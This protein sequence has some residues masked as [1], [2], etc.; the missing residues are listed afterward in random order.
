MAEMPGQERTERATPKRVQDARREGRIPRSRELNT[1]LMMLAASGGM[2]VLGGG[3][4]SGMANL[5]RADF[6]ISR[7]QIFDTAQM[8]R[9]FESASLDALAII[10]P[11]MLLMLLVAV[12][13]PM[14]LGG[15][16]FSTEALGVK[17]ERLDP[18]KGFGRIFAANGLVELVKSMAKVALIGACAL[19]VLQ[20]QAPALLELSEE[21]SGA[22]MAHAMH[23]AGVAFLAM[24]ASLVIVAI[25]DVPFQ[26][27]E[28]GRGL[29]MS[30]QEV[31]DEMKDTEGKPEV[32]GRI[33]RL[34]QEVAR[35]RMMSEVPK[36][37]VIVTN[38]VHY[39]VALRYDE[40]RMR[41]PRVVAKGAELIAAR[42]REVGAEHRV[43]L[44]RAPMLA[45]ALYFNTDIGEEIPAGLY[46][47]VA[48]V[49]AYVFGLRARNDLRAELPESALPNLDI[50]EDLRR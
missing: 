25:A 23:L 45:R 36:A 21:P 37:D 8:T 9:M 41:A 32:R 24:S 13:A 40:K 4:A 15:F 11:F 44:L 43:P 3:I 47:A 42:I 48:Q 31:R 30:R 22:A 5:M 33:R 7:A 14:L 46:K 20:Y 50:P 35:R 1:L 49:L 38:P 6:Q 34:Q 17:W 18:V 29:R 10:A 16:S 2:L 27:W 12:T 28:H 19:L 39:A 26:L